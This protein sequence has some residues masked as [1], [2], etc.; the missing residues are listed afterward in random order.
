MLIVCCSLYGDVRRV[1][2]VYLLRTI[3]SHIFFDG[4]QADFDCLCDKAPICFCNLACK[5][6]NKKKIV[7]K[8]ATKDGKRVDEG[9]GIKI[10][11]PCTVECN[12]GL[13]NERQHSFSYLFFFFSSCFLLVC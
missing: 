13:E 6:I 1:C 2:L 10:N 11:M 12:I 8:S 5:K 9:K 7:K 3:K 4:S